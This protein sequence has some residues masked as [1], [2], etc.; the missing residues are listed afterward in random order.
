MTEDTETKA[1]PGAPVDHGRLLKALRR[2]WR[3]IPT[4]VLTGALLGLLAA[5]LLMKPAYTAKST[6]MWEPES[7]QSSDRAFTTRADSIKL[8]SNLREVKRR[9][10]ISDSLE[11][12]S[13]K[14]SVVFDS[15]SHLV[16]VEA[17]DATAKGAALLAQTTVNVFLDSL[18]GIGHDRG[19]EQLGTYTEDLKVAEDQ[20]LATRI[21]YDKFRTAN[22]VSDYD[23]EL[24]ASLTRVSEI[25][26]DLQL[27]EAEIS[28]EAVRAQTLSVEGSK[29]SNTTTSMESLTDP[30]AVQLGALQS[31]LAAETSHLSNDHPTIIR[32]RAQIAELK[33]SRTGTV[34]GAATVVINPL[35]QGIEQNLVQSRLSRQAAT[36]RAAGLRVLLAD[37]KKRLDQL[38]SIQGKAT[39]F[40]AALTAQEAHKTELAAIRTQ[41]LDKMRNSSVD[42]RVVTAATQPEKPNPSKRRAVVF[43]MP[44]LFLVLGVLGILGYE[45][46]GLRVHTA[47]EA[48]FWANTAVVASS[49][50]PRDQHTLD[51]LINEL[52]DA[53][54]AV[55]GTTLVIGARPTEVPMAREIAYWLSTFTQQGVVGAE[56]SIVGNQPEVDLPLTPRSN[57][58][59]AL[60]LRGQGSALTLAQAWEGPV[61]GPVLRR[62]SRLANRVLVVVAAGTITVTEL[63]QLRSRLGREQGVA[64]LLVGLNPE[65]VS[66]PDR[67]GEVNEFWESYA[68]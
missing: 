38:T 5:I 34:R 6:L 16:T 50:W 37:A 51:N 47:R 68:A 36:S 2:S 22:G 65:F 4:A 39:Q 32:L 53:A 26:K 59:A 45:I 31:Q 12:L 29:L 67:V 44:M 62:A 18:R 40:Q 21:E 42:F 57:G 64:I 8:A 46:R 17:E 1:R 52:S 60:A 49:T 23:A 28:T 14:I 24:K 9:L 35:K 33:R 55:Q 63:A 54:P 19:S 41:T 66:L 10:K 15:Q 11:D 20:L 48:G 30:T 27:A 61:Q 25:T 56:A 7:Q 43:T 58:G 3:I 13:K